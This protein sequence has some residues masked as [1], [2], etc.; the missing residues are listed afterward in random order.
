MSTNFIRL[1]F[2]FLN[3]LAQ[4]LLLLDDASSTGLLPSPLPARSRCR[5]WRVPGTASSTCF[6]GFF[7]NLGQ[8]IEG[9]IDYLEFVALPAAGHRG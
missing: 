2:P 6:G 3:C 7:I 1:R 5:T 4:P 9:P 8:F